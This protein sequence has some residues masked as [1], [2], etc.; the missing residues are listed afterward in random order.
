MKMML[1]NLPA[2]RLKYSKTTRQ[3]D[4]TGLWPPHH[5]QGTPLRAGWRRY[6]QPGA[7]D[8][9]AGT[10]P[11]RTGKRTFIHVANFSAAQF[12]QLL[13]PLYG[14]PQSI[15]SDHFQWTDGAESTVELRGDG[16]PVLDYRMTDYTWDGIRRAFH[17][18]AK[19]QFAAGAK[20]VAPVHANA[21][22]VKTLDEAKALIDCLDLILFQTH[23]GST[24]VMGGCT[25]GEYPKMAVTDSLGRH[26]QLENLS[27]HDG[28]LFPTSIGANPQ[29]SVYGL[30]TKLANLLVERLKA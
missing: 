6:Q 11:A 21:G 19:I 10:G 14:A 28:S 2:N 23:L 27:I 24:H 20:A 22:Y 4:S 17:N 16:S 13:N 7:A 5:G 18:M 12:K 29:L 26:H 8:T 9:L 3:N 25:M 1:D 30:A 15:Y